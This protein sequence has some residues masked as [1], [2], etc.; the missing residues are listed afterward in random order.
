ME[1][2]WQANW[3]W[4]PG[5]R[6]KPNFYFY[7][8]KTF[9]LS[10]SCEQAHLHITAYT[11]YM[12]YVNG[13]FLGRG[14]SPSN[15][16]VMTYDTYDIANY[17]RVG[18]NVIAVF[19]HNYAV[20]VHWNPAG[21][22]GLI[23]QAAIKAGSQAL[24]LATDETWKVKTASCYDPCSPRMMFSC[25]YLE[26][27]HMDKYEASWNTIGYDDSAWSK[28]EIIGKTPV[29]PYER[30]IPKPIPF[31]REERLEP[32]SA[33]KAVYTAEGFHAVS[34]R[35]IE[36]PDSNCLYY[37]TAY[38][39]SD[40]ERESILL[41]SCDD[42]FAVFLN[43]QKILE[44]SYDEQFMRMG[45]FWGR[46]EYEQFHNG[47]GS[48][49]EQAKVQLIKGWNKLTVAVDQGAQGWGFAMGFHDGSSV[50]D[51]TDIRLLSLLFAATPDGDV[52]SWELK[53]PFESSGMKNSLQFINCD[54]TPEGGQTEMHHPS[55][56]SIT[57]YQLLMRTETRSGFT[58][59]SPHAPVTMNEGEC[60]LVDLGKMQV[61]Y[62]ALDIDSQGEAVLDIYVGNVLSEQKKPCGMSELRNVDRLYLVEGLLNWEAVSRR[63]GRYIHICCR[64]G[65]G[66]H[67][68][69]ICMTKVGYPVES[70]DSFEC[71]D[72]LLNRI[73]GASKHSTALIMHHNYEDCLRREEGLHNGRNVIHAFMA[74]YYAF[75]DGLLL[76]K[77][78]QDLL[79]TQNDQGWISGSGPSDD[80]N[81][82]ISK[83][84]WSLEY[85]LRYYQFTGDADFIRQV[86]EQVRCFM[87]YLSRLENKLI[88][89][90]GKNEYNNARGRS[91]WIDDHVVLN[92]WPDQ[93]QMLFSF[94]A[95]YY[96]TLLN[97]AGLSD[98]VGEQLDAA[99]YR[100]K[101]A[102]L[103]ESFNRVFWDDRKEMYAD[104]VKDNEFAHEI[105][106]AYLILALYYG[107]CDEDKA[108]HVLAWLFD[109]Q[110]GTLHN[111]M[112]YRFTFG[113]YYFIFTVMFKYGM[114][115]MAYDLMRTYFGGWLD[116]GFTAF[117]EHFM[118]PEATG[119]KTLGREINVHT[120]S[121]AAHLFFYSHILGI[122]PAEPGFQKTI[123][124]PVPCD[125]L[126]AEG[127]ACTPLGPLE[128]TWNV[129]REVINISVAAPDGME[130]EIVIPEG[131]MRGCVKLTVRDKVS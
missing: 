76:K 37:A 49:K 79:Y 107:I 54:A 78:F 47:I 104:W 113:Y 69:S 19:A 74:S 89:I 91:I 105:Q 3:I 98:A 20:G 129:D 63:D 32:V 87:R 62:T 52:S 55:I 50:D 121:T 93:N 128:V 46:E 102:Y 85:L 88:L 57:D 44:Q 26:T 120:D 80:T 83:A 4:H 43:G 28:P 82:E 6:Q 11:D 41:L 77:M 109:E 95:L 56:L 22:G 67:L 17:L 38:F 25:R 10:D 92:D 108:Q 40:S 111:Y 106:D 29:F 2:Q 42:A 33:E 31:L 90:D 96:G 97:M 114:D 15:G 30:L 34:F 127:S 94:N 53:G 112:D 65:Q 27:F 1:L 18:E 58:T 45:L 61:G 13:A 125:I 66:V 23:V 24:E 84:M 124:A 9:V 21:P 100:Q 7:A 71:S 5:M 51:R 68:N 16:K 131:F 12:L 122:R 39:H 119:R 60:L 116:L 101:A 48:R 70:K 99:F 117:G 81:D 103:K 59:I 130:C 110:T 115:R 36:K 14:P 73:Y 75:G 8:R 86:Y 118:L 35:D 64:K 126:W 123:V 72:E